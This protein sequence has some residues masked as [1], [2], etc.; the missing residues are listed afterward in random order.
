MALTEIEFELTAGQF[1]AMG[2]PALRQG[3]PL[4]LVL[5]GGLLFPDAGAESWFTVQK[6][7]VTSLLEQVGPA[8]YAFQGQIT[9]AE[10]FK[11]AGEENAILTVQCGEL[12]LRVACAPQADGTLPFGTWETRTLAGMGRI[13]GIVEEAFTSAIGTPV[14][15]TIWRFRRLILTPGDVLFGQWRESAELPPQPFANDRI[16]VTARIH[17]AR[18]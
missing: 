6:E 11:D 14:N 9:A 15:V 1:E 2:Y 3:Q 10:L 8:L 17:R 16:Y 4:T 18:A 12:P 13:T 7:P 5:D